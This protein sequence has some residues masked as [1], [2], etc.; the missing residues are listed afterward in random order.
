MCPLGHWQGQQHQAE[1]GHWPTAG[2][3]HHASILH[4]GRLLYSGSSP[5]SCSQPADDSTLPI[6]LA[7]VNITKAVAK[8]AMA[9]ACTT[10][11]WQQGTAQH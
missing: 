10:C 4:T 2:G 11:S 8:A 3:Q 5:L 6:E 9:E 7:P 1:M